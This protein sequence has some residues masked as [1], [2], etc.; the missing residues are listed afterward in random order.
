M[1]PPAHIRELPGGVGKP[2][3]TYMRTRILVHFTH[4]SHKAIMLTLQRLYDNE[5]TQYVEK[6]LVLTVDAL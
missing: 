5:M 4:M 3:V 1:E 2:S 6:H